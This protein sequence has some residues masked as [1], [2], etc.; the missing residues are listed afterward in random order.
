M[1]RIGLIPNFYFLAV[2]NL[3]LEVPVME[4]PW[5]F[6]LWNG[7]NMQRILRFKDFRHVISRP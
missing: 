3:V 2:K 6:Q 7:F 5:K 4:R 1:R